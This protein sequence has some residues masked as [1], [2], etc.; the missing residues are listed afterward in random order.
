MK[1]DL[2]LEE[3]GLDGQTEERMDESSLLLGAVC[4]GFFRTFADLGQKV[5]NYGKVFC[6][7]STLES[8]I[9]WC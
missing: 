9:A 4:Q 5:Y 7:N 3:V 1:I 8:E 2:C 6:I